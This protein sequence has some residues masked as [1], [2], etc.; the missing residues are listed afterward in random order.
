MQTE[1]KSLQDNKTWTVVPLPKGKKAIGCRWVYKI[2]YK[3][4]CEVERFKSRLVTKGYSQ[5]EG[6]DY[7]ETFSPV[8]KMVTVRT[9]NSLASMNNW[10]IHQMDVYNASFQGSKS[11]GASLEVNKKLTIPEFDTQFG[12]GDDKVLDD[13]SSYQQL[14]GRLLYLT[15]TRPDIAFCSAIV[16]SEPVYV[17]PQDVT[18]EGCHQGDQECETVPRPGDINEIGY[19]VSNQV[20]E[21]IDLMKIE[22]VD[23]HIQKLS[24]S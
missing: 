23:H 14:I 15:M 21:F 17:V 20:W 16:M 13:P 6:L 1:I 22:K 11:A 24:R 7:Q 10:D 2:K 19:W 3:A 5:K 12:I 9:M 18:Y 8:A 4:T